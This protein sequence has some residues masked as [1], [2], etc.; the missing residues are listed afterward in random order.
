MLL[1]IDIGNTHTVI[2]LFEEEKLLYHWRISSNLARTEDEVGPVLLFLF[3]KNGYNASQIT[4]VCIS[5]VVPDLT[6]VYMLFSKKYFNLQPLIIHSQVNLG[7]KVKYLEPA[8]V[9]A[10]RLCNAVAGRQKY[11]KPLIIIDFGTAT[12]FD[13]INA[14]GDYLGGLISPG[15]DTSIKSL[16]LKAAKLPLVELTFPDKLIGRTTEE[17]IQSGVLYGAIFMIEGLIPA[18][19]REL[20]SKT[21]TLATGGLSKKIA[22]RTDL[23]DIVDQYLSL[24]GI[25]MIYKMNVPEK[26]NKSGQ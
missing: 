8:S 5:S 3:E 4:G 20:G 2:G 25:A 6:P 18:I 24:D 1:A 7:L 11:G 16:H 14:D 10:D 15:I 22:K 12:T 13:C 26:K 9:G 19:K 23:I 17:S 21:K